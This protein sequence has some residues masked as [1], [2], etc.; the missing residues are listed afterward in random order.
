MSEMHLTSPLR[1][2][3][4]RM[5]RMQWQG[6]Q[7]L[8]FTPL[9]SSYKFRGVGVTLSPLATSATDSNIAPA[10]DDRW[11]VWTI[12]W[13]ENWQGKPMHSEKTCL[14]ATLSTTNPTWPDLGSNPDNRGRKPVTNCLSYGTALFLLL[15]S[16]PVV[17]VVLVVPFS[18]V[19]FP[20]DDRKQHTRTKQKT[21]HAALCVCGEYSVGISAGI[22]T[23]RLSWVFSAPPGKCNDISGLG[24]HRFL[25]DTFHLI[26]HPSILRSAV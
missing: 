11:W 10:P 22:Q 9:F 6:I 4:R 8:V 20:Q 2:K 12:W 14:S 3:P 26:S 1:T 7:M 19:F 13:N 25:S 16:C 23:M 5:D 17:C 21:Q 24:R 15:S 18:P